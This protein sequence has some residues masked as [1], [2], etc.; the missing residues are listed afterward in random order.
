MVSKCGEVGSRTD[1]R[2]VCEGKGSK[3]GDTKKEGEKWRFEEEATPNNQGMG[4]MAPK[5]V[6]RKTCAAAPEKRA[7]G[8]DFREEININEV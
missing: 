3:K 8:E 2:G 4:E 6:R 1:R 5:T 7:K